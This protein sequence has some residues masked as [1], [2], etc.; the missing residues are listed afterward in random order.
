[1]VSL[2][3]L[4]D[5]ATADREIAAVT[6]IAD[7]QRDPLFRWQS[8]VWRSMRA[9]LE[10]DFAPAEALAGE[11]HAAAERVQSHIATPVYLGQVF[12]IRWHQGRLGELTDM[13]RALIDAGS[14]VPAL[15]CGLAQCALQSGDL[16]L[17]RR[18][19][20]LL[21]A[22]RFAALPHDASRLATL[23]NLA[24]AI[25]RVGAFEHASSLYEELL[26]YAR[27][28]V[29]VGPGLGYFGAVTRHLGLLAAGAGRLADAERHFADALERDGRMGARAWVA[30][31]QGDFAALLLLRGEAGDVER[32]S[33]CAPRPCAPPRRSTCRSSS[34]SS[35]RSTRYARRRHRAPHPARCRAAWCTRVTSGPCASTA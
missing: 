29:V 18:E 9:S 32:R 31:T 25:C 8:L 5:V 24:E 28:T 15:H 13:V 27:L 33:S 2:L 22:G 34:S 6:H 16:E 20:D 19:I 26:P 30:W 10:G 3:E 1:V 14:N 4:G 12:G 21:S 23:A 35:G 11:A 17:V 7:E